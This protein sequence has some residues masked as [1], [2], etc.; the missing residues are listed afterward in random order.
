MRFPSNGLT[1]LARSLERILYEALHREMG[2]NLSK[3]LRFTSLGIKAKKVE[4]VPPPTLTLLW[5]PLIILS[6]SNLIMSQK[7]M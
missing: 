7:I 1:L 3:D 4:L 6:R 2:L 5:K